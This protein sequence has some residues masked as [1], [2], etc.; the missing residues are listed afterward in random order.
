MKM[1]KAA[2]VAA[3]VAVV[4]VQSA[5]AR[6]LGDI[7]T[8]CG[9]GGLIAQQTP[10]L[11]VTT[12]IV[13]DL[14]LTATSSELTTPESCKGGKPAAA[15]LILQAYPA[16]ERELAQGRGEHLDALL[17]IASCDEGARANVTAALRTDFGALVNAAV[18]PQQTRLEQAN[19]LYQA[20]TEQVEGSFAGSC[21]L[22]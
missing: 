6:D 17:A 4:P 16:L 14:G 7:Y 12:N 15:A 8:Q 20:F 13:W 22:A 5:V 21:N 3:T 18:Y 9:L 2:F 1:L 10:W 11:A 19:G